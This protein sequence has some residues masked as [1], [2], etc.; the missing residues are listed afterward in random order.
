MENDT[1]GKAF[2]AKVIG[3]LRRRQGCEVFTSETLDLVHKIDG[4]IRRIGGMRLRLPVQVQITRRVDHFNKLQVYLASRW[5]NADIVSLYVEVHDDPGVQETAAHIAWAAKEV[6][7]LPPYGRAPIFGLRIDDDAAF[8]DPHA[9]LRELQAE[10]DSPERLAA[11]RPGTVYRYAENG[12][13]IMDDERQT[14]HFAHYVDAS[15]RGLRDRLREREL[16]LEVRFLPV[17]RSRATDVR[18]PARP[19]TERDRPPP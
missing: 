9:R 7:T 11:L 6:Q 8:F 18:P 19:P 12:F 14:T 1:P 10:R 17:G 15:N 13:W 3:A 4:E 16:Q 2:E 5:L